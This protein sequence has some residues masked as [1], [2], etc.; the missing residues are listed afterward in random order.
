[1]DEQASVTW[2]DAGP[3]RVPYELYKSSEIYADE[4]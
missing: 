1:M 2:P 4:R 3:S